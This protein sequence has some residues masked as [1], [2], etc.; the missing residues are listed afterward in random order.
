MDLSDFLGEAFPRHSLSKQGKEFLIP[1]PFC[2][3]RHRDGKQKLS[4]SLDKRLFHCWRCDEK[5]TLRD[6]CKRLN[7]QLPLS[8]GM[9]KLGGLQSSST[10]ESQELGYLFPQS[11]SALD[12]D[13]ASTYLRNRGVTDAQMLEYSLL[14]CSQGLYANRIIVPT[15][16]DRELVYFVARSIM[17]GVGTKKYL[18]PPITVNCVF[19]LDKAS[20]FDRVVICEGVFSAIAAGKNA[21]AL[22]GK[23]MRDPQLYRLLQ[24]N[25]REYV[26]MLDPDAGNKA[27]TKIGDALCKYGAVVKVAILKE[28]DPAEVSRDTVLQSINDSIPFEHRSKWLQI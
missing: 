22:F 13:S 3:P 21:I 8:M 12:V 7:L 18:N 19:N 15:L 16:E 9:R 2:S 17:S 5:G 1:C 24:A 27:I 28:G 4:I 20:E 14:F 25:F 11:V 23:V 6:L 10:L 26:I